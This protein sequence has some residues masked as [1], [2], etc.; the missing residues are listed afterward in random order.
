MHLEARSDRILGSAVPGSRAARPM[1]ALGQFLRSRRER[2]TPD[3]VGLRA[4]GRR[5]APGLRREEVAQLAGVSVAWYT[6]L[7]QG[8][9]IHPSGATLTWVATALR[10]TREERVHLFT[11]AGQPLPDPHVAEDD[12]VPAGVVRVL[13]Q[14]A[15]PAY[16]AGG[17]LDVLAWNEA[18]DAL[19]G[20][21]RR[22]PVDRNSLRMMFLDPQFRAMVVD[23][24][25][26]AAQ[27]VAT[28]R[29]SADLHAD[30]PRF[31]RM[32]EDLSRDS[33]E[34]RKL[35]A[36]H[37]VKARRPGIKQLIH[38]TVGTLSLEHQAF[39]CATPALCMVVYT[40]VDAADTKRLARLVAAHRKSTGAVHRGP[41]QRNSARRSR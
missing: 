26:V 16:V 7:E 39:Q 2:V 38:P 32:L 10:L 37:D 5:R 23:W 13:D 41:R 9:D 15:C 34:F 18:A 24:L 21:T 22:A 12:P 8:R 4:I 3:Q 35:W 19:F 30:D 40:P 17:R 31:A 33:A 11:L 27:L 6:W 1:R 20:F 25:P 28:F 29:T 14:I 36:K